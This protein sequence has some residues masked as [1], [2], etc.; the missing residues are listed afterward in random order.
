MS[1]GRPS[2]FRRTFLIERS[3]QIKFILKIVSFVAFATI[4]TGVVTY[5]LTNEELERS[6]YSIH[7]QIKNVWQI[8]LPAV[9]I[10]S[11]ITT[12][13]VAFFTTFISLY[14][15]H[16]IGG[17]LFRFKKSLKEIGTGDLSVVTKLRASD[18]LQELT[19]NINTMTANLKEKVIR[20]DKD[21]DALKEQ[22]NVMNESFSSKS[23][24]GDKDKELLR[25]LN[26]R[27]NE[28]GEDIHQF[29]FEG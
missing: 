3:Y 20:I 11:F 23:G 9:V 8:L 13:I 24:L 26:K 21:Y 7:Y 6:F 5:F 2:F 22:A 15:S 27:I 17:P 18:E 28:L 19:D 10:I 4:I 12:A 29:K 16:K 25:V 14:E 1:K